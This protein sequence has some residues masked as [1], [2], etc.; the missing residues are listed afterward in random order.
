MLKN[1]F[2]S[3]FLLLILSACNRNNDEVIINKEY[4]ANGQL[5][6]EAKFVNRHKNGYYNAY[7][8]N[9]NLRYITFYKNDSIDG[10]FSSYDSITHKNYFISY[11]DNGVK[12]GLE[13]AFYPNGKLSALKDYKRSFDDTINDT[14]LNQ[15]LYLDSLGKIWEYSYFYTKKVLND[16]VKLSFVGYYGKYK[17]AYI[18][19]FNDSYSLKNKTYDSIYFGNTKN[20]SIPLS[21]LKKHNTTKILVCDTD[22]INAHLLGP[23]GTY[24]NRIYSTYHT[25][26][27]DIKGLIK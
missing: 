5:K 25:V 10:I 23:D 12:T 18:S 4:Y 3:L 1:I 22:T 15:E 2:P 19:N 16:A 13:T 6:S 17:K 27:I 20:I 21:L 9:G 26:Q 24:L 11:L 7:Y 8:A 14:N